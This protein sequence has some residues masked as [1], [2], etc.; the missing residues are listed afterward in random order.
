LSP[1]VRLEQVGR[2]PVDLRRVACGAILSM[3]IGGSIEVSRADETVVPVFEEPLHRLVLERGPVRVLDVQLQPGDT[4]LYHLHDDP[5]FYVAIDISE[6]DAQVLGE[7]WRRTRVSAWPPGGVAHDLGHAEQP[8]IHRIRNAGDEAFRLIA[9]TNGGPPAPLAGPG[10]DAVLPGTVETEVEW[11]R[12][13]RVI[14]APGTANGPIRSGFP[15]VVVQVSPGT[16]ELTLGDAA[17]RAVLSGP[18][19]F[20]YVDPGRA[21]GLR[22]PGGLQVT[23]VVVEAR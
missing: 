1:R 4:S 19:R 11:F 3:L 8:L 13:S 6:I 5:I 12:Q 2:P 17:N 16:A 21:F 20:V 14:L 7:E 9:V 22:N 15:V 10:I 18:G 23:L